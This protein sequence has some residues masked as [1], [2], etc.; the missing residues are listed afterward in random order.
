VNPYYFLHIPI[1]DGQFGVNIFFVI[2]GFL[3]TT[4]LLQE[5]AQ[6][7]S[8]SLKAFY[9]RRALRI[10]PAYYFLLLVYWILQLSGYLH[11]SHP[12]WLTALTYTKYLNYR[13]E[14]Y[15]A[16]AWSLG[17]EETFYLFW[18]LLFIGGEKIRKNT[19][20]SI[21]LIVPIVRSWLYFY[22]VQWIND[23]SLFTRIDA[24]AMGCFF[25]L[26]QATIINYLSPHWTKFFYISVTGLFAIPWL[27]ELSDS[28]NFSL[29]FVSLGI[30]HGTIANLLIATIMMYSVFGPPSRWFSILNSKAF[31]YVGLLSYSLYLWQQFYISGK[32]TWITQFP[33]NTVLIF[34]TAMVSYYL[35]EKPF[36]KLKSRFSLKKKA[37][38]FN[39]QLKPKAIQQQ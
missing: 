12:A 19:I 17:I 1:F 24:I 25:A 27:A 21:I 7:G 13:I 14:W 34:L 38:K 33:Q 37:P 36:L 30:L 3:I 35:I 26:Y 16:H 5:E 28:S 6:T 4:L 18:P 15:T 32:N 23:Q 8:I 11:I 39:I 29:L 9:T 22:P 20:I 10:F 31:N 2:S